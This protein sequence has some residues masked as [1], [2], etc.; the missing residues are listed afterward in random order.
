MEKRNLQGSNSSAVPTADLPSFNRKNPNWLPMQPLAPVLS[1][2]RRP[3]RQ[4]HFGEANQITHDRHFYR[5]R[6]RRAAI[7]LRSARKLPT[8]TVVCIIEA[9]KVMNEIRP[10]QGHRH[11]RSWLKTANRSIRPA[12]VQDSLHLIARMTLP[13]PL[14]TG[15]PK[16]MFENSGSQPAEKSPS[17]SSAPAKLNIPHGRRLFRAACQ[18]HASDGR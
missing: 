7:M 2:P 11:P 5:A 17:A 10:G 4:P 3:E 1:A 6:R 18:L 15:F 12:V 13:Q 8:E 9:M 16:R 14:E